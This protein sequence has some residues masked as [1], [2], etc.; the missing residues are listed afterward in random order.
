VDGAPV[1][2]YLPKGPVPPI[3]SQLFVERTGL[4]PIRLAL[5]LEPSDT[6]AALAGDWQIHLNR[7]I[8]LSALVSLLKAAHLTMFALMGYSYALTTAGR[9]VG[10]DILGLFTARNMGRNRPTV[11][12]DAAEHFPEF[13]NLVRP[14]A[15]HPTGLTGTVTDRQLFLCTGTPKAWAFMILI[16]TGEQTHAVLLPVM[17]DDDSAARFLRFLSDPPRR[18]EIKLAKFAGDRWEV[19]KT[20][21]MIDWPDARFDDSAAPAV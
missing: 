7:D 12:A 2:H 4:P 1:S 17:E 14:M 21:R 13:V 8:R 5:K 6:L 16:R 18:F 9:F 3:H 11:L 10:W 19:A 20:G 15:V